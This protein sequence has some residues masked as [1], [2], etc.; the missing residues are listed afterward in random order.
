M[1]KAPSQAL[2][3]VLV[4]LRA[5]RFHPRPVLISGAAAAL[6]WALVVCAAIAHDGTL[7]LTRDYVAYLGSHK[8]LIG[9]EVER[10]VALAALAVFLAVATRNARQIL[11]RA[12]HASDYAEALNSARRHLDEATSA[13]TRAKR[14]WRELDRHKAE[15]SEQ[16]RRFDAALENMS[17]GICMFDKEQ[18]LIVCNRRYARM[19]G[20]P[21]ERV[22][23]GTTLREILD[24]RVV[25]GLYGGGSPQEY[26]K[27]RLAKAEANVA[28]TNVQEFTDGRSHRHRAPADAGRAAGSPPTRTSPSCAASRR[29]SPTSPTTTRSPTCPTACCCASGSTEALS[30]RT[31]QAARLA[32]LVLDLDRFKDVNDTLGHSG[33]RRAAA[34]Q[35][36]ERLR[37]CVGEADTVARLGRRRVRHHAG[38]ADEPAAEAA[39]LAKRISE[40]HRRSPSISTSSSAVIGASIGIAVAPGDGSDADELL[41]NADLALYRA[42]SEGAAQYRFFEPEM[43]DA[44]AGAPRCWSATC[45]DALAQRRVRAALPAARQPGAR[46]GLRAA[47]R[48]CAGIIPSA[49]MVSPPSSFRWPRRPA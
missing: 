46:R 43:D 25:H 22:R 10:L 3:F 14:R 47:R 16:N 36:A 37:G 8:I 40:A 4:A 19:Y 42:K 9:A 23:P 31:R 35:S 33:R 5:L 30:Q 29:A 39:A 20:L 15:L 44:H 45:S 38:C 1:L 21:D 6:G 24:H 18:R 7:G 34:G 12:A 17:Q 28:T 41:K 49:G 32:V 27:E 2:L 13:R 26:I 11:S 48:C